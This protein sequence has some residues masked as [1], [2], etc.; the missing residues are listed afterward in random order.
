MRDKPLCVLEFG[1]KAA[2]K[3]GSSNFAIR[4]SMRKTFAVVT[5][6]LS[7]SISALADGIPFDRDT[8]QVTEKHVRLT[9]SKDQKAEYTRDKT[10]TLTDNQHKKLTSL[11]PAFPA[12][13]SEVLSYRYGDCTCCIGRP[14][15]ILLPDAESIAIPH[16]EAH[17]VTRHGPRGRPDFVAMTQ[18][19]KSRWSAFWSRF[20]RRP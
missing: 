18:S 19:K 2:E 10:I 8:N 4:L 5:A 14:Y 9:L 13:I 15:A 11:S 7:P 17:Y 1:H 16:S 20:F 12:K 3:L 6:L